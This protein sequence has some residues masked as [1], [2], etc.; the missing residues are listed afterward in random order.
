MKK[1]MQKIKDLWNK[2]AEWIVTQYNKFLP[3]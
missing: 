3:K 1:I 2:V